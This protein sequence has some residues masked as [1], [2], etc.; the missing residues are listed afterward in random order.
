MSDAAASAASQHEYIAG[1]RRRH[2]AHTVVVELRERNGVETQD[3]HDASAKTAFVVKVVR[4]VRVFVGFCL[5][6]WLLYPW[7]NVLFRD[8][9]IKQQ[10]QEEVCFEE[11]QQ[12]HQEQEQPH[13]RPAFVVLLCLFEPLP[14]FALMWMTK[15]CKSSP[16]AAALCIVHPKLAVAC[17]GLLKAYN[18]HHRLMYFGYVAYAAA[19]IV[20]GDMF[21]IA[22]QVLLRVLPP[23]KIQ[24]LKARVEK[25]QKDDIA[26][27]P[28]K[29][30]PR[31][32]TRS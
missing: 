15:S 19:D 31:A 26:K 14:Q 4:Y 23:D 10:E 11:N 20:F 24:A 13:L 27:A 32:N 17:L 2:H 18:V 22:V 29:K 1:R 5:C 21:S 30:P 28:Q 7:R 6:A 9:A 25:A 8:Q 16:A 3:E 12:Q